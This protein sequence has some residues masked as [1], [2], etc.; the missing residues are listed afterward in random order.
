MGRGA[1]SKPPSSAGPRGK[2]ETKGAAE[3]ALPSTQ[4][5]SYAEIEALVARVQAANQLQSDAPTRASHLLFFLMLT[6]KFPVTPGNDGVSRAALGSRSGRTPCVKHPHQPP[7]RGVSA[8]MHLE[9]KGPQRQPR[10][11]L[12]RRLEEVAEAVGGG[13]CWLQMPLKLAL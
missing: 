13:Y 6:Q 9:G 3:A 12:D 7:W 1:A 4:V 10:K 2:G 8:G 5:N 11:R